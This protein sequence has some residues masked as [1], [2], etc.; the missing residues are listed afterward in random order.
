METK[1]MSSEMLKSMIRRLSD[2]DKEILD[3]VL[4]Y[5]Y[6]TTNQIRR[7]HFRE[8]KSENTSLRTANRTL[9]KLKE[10]QLLTPLKRRIGGVR[11]G[12]AS[13]VW[14]LSPLGAR[15]LMQMGKKSNKTARKRLYVPSYSFLTHTLAVSE[16]SI[17][18]MEFSF[19]GRVSLLKQQLEPECWREH[20]G[21]GGA[22]KYL[23]PDLAAVTSSGE[24]EDY[25]FIEL[26]LS[27]E[28]PA[29]VVRKCKQYAAYKNSGT[30]QREYGVFPSVVWIVPDGN[31]KCSLQRH[32]GE[33]MHGD[34]NIF[35]VITL[36]ELE[37]LVSLGIED[38]QKLY[39]DSGGKRNE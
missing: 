12:S 1:R 24:Y 4:K 22:L 10:Y 34:A 32:I 38:F 36:D 17:K 35:A 21:F 5:R 6:L 11:A 20:V 27:T 25:W 2:R 39:R 37:Y 29:T 31:R 23:K 16:L 19:L 15:A 26:D 14:T 9:A 8:A 7:F 13:Y 18:L 30:E 3:S 28:S 33:Q